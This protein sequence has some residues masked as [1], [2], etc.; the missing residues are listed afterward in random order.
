M[1]SHIIASIAALLDALGGEPIT[2]DAGPPPR[3][4]RTLA[5]EMWPRDLRRA[6]IMGKI[7]PS[8]GPRGMPAPGRLFKGHRP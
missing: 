6:V 2:L 1:K 4:G 3:R 8:R 5:C 7:R